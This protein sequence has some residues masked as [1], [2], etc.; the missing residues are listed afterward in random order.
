[1]RKLAAALAALILTAAVSGCAADEHSGN[2]QQSYSG[3]SAEVTAG[4]SAEIP[5]E[6]AETAEPAGEEYHETT[7]PAAES[8][9]AADPVRLAEGFSAEFLGLPDS[10]KV[11]I[12]RDKGETVQINGAECLGVSCYDEVDGQLE[13]ICDF[14]I[15]PDGGTAYRF[16]PED[17]TY[18]LLPEQGDFPGFDPESQSPEE[19]FRQANALYAAV[20]GELDFDSAAEP[21][22]SAAGNFYPVSD[23]RLDTAEKLDSA[24]SRYFAGE[25]L[26][27]LMGGSDNV[28]A[29]EDGRLYCLE[30]YGAAESPALEYSLGEL[31]ESTAVYHCA[32]L[33]EYEAG[34]TVREEFTCTAEKIPEAGWRF[35]DF[36]CPGEQ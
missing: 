16:H 12:F 27:R 29:A 30:H 22:T 13:S 24:L 19:V 10:G 33:F 9:P 26:E 31:T 35:T 20:Y 17:G 4:T 5:E 2:T 34:N 23:E 18:R 15:A 25:V 21:I 36:T 28:S 7:E 11:Y 32:A 3:A 6:T 14:Y 1:M 8:V